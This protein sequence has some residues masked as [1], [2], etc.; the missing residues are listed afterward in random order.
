MLVA[1]S[2]GGESPLNYALRN[3]PANLRAVTTFFLDA[4][5]WLGGLQPQ[6]PTPEMVDAAGKLPG[7]LSNALSWACYYNR[8]PVVAQLLA[9][10]EV[11]PTRNDSSCLRSAASDGHTSIVQLLLADGRADPGAR[12]QEAIVVASYRGHADTV[13]VLLGDPRVDPTAQNGWALKTALKAGLP[14]VA[15]LLKTDPRM[16]PWAHLTAESP[17]VAGLW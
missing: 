8:V 1:K 11:D 13:A 3:G 12:D 2:S 6:P 4:A 15:A 9:C 5:R 7:V 17:V 10:P 16:A 14:A